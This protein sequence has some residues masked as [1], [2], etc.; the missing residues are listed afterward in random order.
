MHKVTAQRGGRRPRDRFGIPGGPA[1]ARVF[2]GVSWPSVVG[3]SF[4]QTWVVLCI[5][6]P[7]PVTY[8]EPFHDL[9]WLSLS[10]ALLCSLAAVAWGR[11][12]ENIER[13]GRFAVAMGVVAALSSLLG[14][15]SA[16]FSPPVSVVLIHLAAIGV[17][18]G[19]ALL[20]LVWYA[21]FCAKR[22]MVGLACSV[23]IS[24]GCI[25]PL[26]NVLSTDQMSPWVS[27]VI[28]SVLPVLSAVLARGEYGAAAPS[29]EAPFVDIRALPE[30][31]RRL[32]LRL[33]VCLFVVIAVAETLRNLLLGG[34]AIAFYAG[35]ANLGGVVLKIA[36]AWW[37]ILVFESRNAR[38]VSVAY[39]LAFITFLGVVLCVP[40]LLQGNW[41]AHT[42]LDIGT[43]FFQMVMLMVAYQITVGFGLRPVT[44]FGIM[45]AVWA[46][47][48]LLG[49]GSESM[50]H[51]FGPEVVQ[52]F[53]VI[54]GLLTAVAILFVFTDQDCVEVLASLPEPEGTD[55]VD[56]RIARLARRS[57]VS[58]RELEVLLYVMRGRSA[59]RIADSLGV[60]PAT[61]NSH[62][63][64]IYQKLGVHSRQELIDAVEKEERE[65]ARA[66]Q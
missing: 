9:R 13:S 21:R 64:H 16:L 17:G 28:G 15:V 36:C 14:P 39:R 5:A 44:S 37:L 54:L 31:K 56:K 20:Y 2:A 50:R 1:G 48:A 49:I 26:A 42:L 55:G 4:A 23:A 62:V 7:D 46:A 59:T 57:G 58:D 35:V 63:H 24:V 65:G 40:F 19:F 60:A 51:V 18:M 11:L 6:L 3:F 33:A 8:G 47:A 10:T 41:I 12:G 27:A 32:C 38:G 30:D 61:V 43:F 52:V 53:P 29:T 22:D 34:T 25:Y 45:R 66:G